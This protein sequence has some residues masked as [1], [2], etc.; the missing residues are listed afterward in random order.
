[1]IAIT[2]L[3]N[4]IAE[5][6]D[7]AIPQPHN[8]PHIPQRLLRHF[9]SLLTSIC[10]NIPHQRRIIQIALRPLAHR[11][12]LGDDGVDHRLLALQATNP[13][14]ATPALHPFLFIVIRIHQMQ[15]SHRAFFRVA[16]IGAFHACRVGGHGL[17]FFR[18]AVGVFAQRNRVVVRL[19]H[20]LPVE[21]R[22]F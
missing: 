12:L 8:L 6:R 4:T 11:L 1:M 17:D 13:R 7:L 18:H 3:R 15:L 14:A 9:S 19:G 5:I 20:F 22:H 2:S 21:A 16:G 10:H